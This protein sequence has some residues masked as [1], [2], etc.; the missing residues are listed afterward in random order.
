MNIPGGLF[1][2]LFLIFLT[3]KL[4]GYIA[5]SWW[6]VFAPL[7]AGM[8]IAILITALAFIVFVYGRTK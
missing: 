5:W 7:I 2:M 1:G 6:L 4:T 3:L 8:V